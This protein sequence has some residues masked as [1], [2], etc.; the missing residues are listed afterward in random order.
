MT[1]L[2]A[3][4]LDAT[5]GLER[6]ATIS[7]QLAEAEG[8][9]ETLQAIVD[10]SVRYLAQC[11]GATL[12]LVEKG[13]RVITPASTDLDAR[14]ADLAQY[15][16]GQGPCLSAM[17]QRVT[18]VIVDMHDEDRWPQWRAAVRELGWRSMLGL[19]LYIADDT[20]GALNIYSR[21]PDGFPAAS[22]L[23]GQV[24]ASIAAVAMKAAISDAG[25]QRALAARDD[26][27]QA[28]GILMERERLT[29]QEAFDRLRQLS[30][31]HDVKVRDLAR[32][33]AE[34]GQLPD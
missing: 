9:D 1:E 28:K 30:N 14:R 20:M 16:T 8:L 19:R 32:D 4:D 10:L 33:I 5:V 25:L 29:G 2:F 13:G 12:M 34:T 7:R 23:L 15:E 24:F 22:Q 31:E 3:E 26:I 18:I 6:V 11:D 27:G 17:Q 21:S